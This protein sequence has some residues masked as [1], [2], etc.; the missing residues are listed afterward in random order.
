M[1]VMVFFFFLLEMVGLET[2]P[3]QPLLPEQGGKKADCHPVNSS[4]F[5]S[6]GHPSISSGGCRVPS[7]CVGREGAV[8]AF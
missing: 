6:S 7:S 3:T 5:F 8:A 2:E 4:P 1:A